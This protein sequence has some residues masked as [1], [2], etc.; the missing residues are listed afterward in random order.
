MM[1]VFFISR[2][3]LKSEDIQR[4]SLLFYNKILEKEVSY[5]FHQSLFLKC[6]FLKIRVSGWPVALLSTPGRDGICS[7]SES[8]GEGEGT[9]VRNWLS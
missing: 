3:W 9:G 7:K 5:F 1:S 2:Q 8:R 4:I 6:E